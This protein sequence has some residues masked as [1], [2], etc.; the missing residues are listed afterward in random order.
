M[1]ESDLMG[2]CAHMTKNGKSVTRLFRTVKKF[3]AEKKGERNEEE[4]EKI[5]IF[6]EWCGTG[7]QK[8]V[9]ISS[10]PRTFVIFAVMVVYEGDKEEQKRWLDLTKLP[11]LKDEEARVFNIVQFPTFKVEIDFGNEEKVEEVKKDMDE[12]T[13]RVEEH[14]PVGKYFG[15]KGVGEGIV[16]QAIGCPNMPE[17]LE[18]FANSRYWFKTKGLKHTQWRQLNGEPAKVK[19]VDPKKQGKID[20]LVEAM[21]TPG[22]LEQGMQVLEREMML[23]IEMCSIGAFTKWVHGDIIKE[24]YD[25]IEAAGVNKKALQ[26]P[27]NFVAKKWYI[28]RLEEM[29]LEKETL[30]KMQRLELKDNVVVG[31]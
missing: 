22:R 20:K 17:K 9:A 13:L 12:L 26:G 19:H 24:E 18:K 15:L 31:I 25:R 23:P 21:L 2:F 6:G 3:L 1:P 16:W 11:E 14:C 8:G 28:E 5:A 10:L 4:V 29:R 7:V 30:E 27:I